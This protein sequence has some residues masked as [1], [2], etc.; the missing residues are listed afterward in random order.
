M[1]E[2]GKDIITLINADGSIKYRSPSYAYVLGYDITEMEDRLIFENVHPDDAATLKELFLQLMSTS[3]A[4]AKGQWRQKHSDGSYRWMEGIGSNLLDDPDVRA[5]ACNFRDI[6]ADIEVKQQ[7]EKSNRELNQLFNSIDEVLYS[8]DRNPYRLTQMS[9]ACMK[10]YG[11]PSSDF[12]AN[13]TLWFDLILPEDSHVIR[14]MNKLAEKG[15]PGSCQYRIRHKDGSIRWIE[16]HVTPTL[17]KNG[18]LARIDGVN[19]DITERKNAEEAL[20]NNEK[21]FRAL[22]ENN[23]E[24]IALIDPSRQFLYLS[25]SIKGILGYEP[26]ELIGT[27]AFELYHPDD[28]THMSEFVRSLIDGNTLYEPQLLRARHKDGNWRWIELIATNQLSDPAV[29]ALVANFRDVTEKKNAEEALLNN[30]KKFRTLI[31]NSKDG[32]VLTNSEARFIYLSPAIKEIL[33]YDPEELIGKYAYDVIHADFQRSDIQNMLKTDSGSKQSAELVLKVKHK[34]GSWRWIEASISLRLNDPSI[35]AVVTNFH[36]VTEKKNAEEALLNSEQRFRKLIEKNKD[37]IGLTDS[38]QQFVYLSPSVKDILGYEPEELIGTGAFEQYHPDDLPAMADLARSIRSEANSSASAQVR[39]RHKDGSW[40]WIELTATNQLDDPAINAIVT[41]F[42][43]VTD[44]K[45]AEE[46][47][48]NSE[49]R[50]RTLIEN[51][52]EGIALSNRDRQYIYVTPSV[53]NILGYDPEELIGVRAIDIY[54]PDDQESMRALVASIREK[55]I[56]FGSN[57]VRIRH[58]NGEWRWIEL[59]ATNQ[60]DD[61]AVNAIVTNFRDVTERKKAEDELEQ[62]N[63]S[64]EKKVQERTIQLEESNKALES[65]S[66]MA[67][68]DLQA[69]LR[70]MSGYTAI[71]KEEYQNNLGEDGIVLLDTI[72]QQAKQM[73]KLVSDLLSFSRVSHTVLKEEKISLDEIVHDI[74]SHLHLTYTSPNVAEIKV[75]KLGC[76]SG[77]TSLIRQVWSNLIS[78]A[79]K[80]SS[81]KEKPLIEIGRIKNDTETVFF[82]K[83]NGAGFDT[84]NASKLFQVFQRLHGSSDFEGTGLGLALVKNIV[85]RHGGRVWAE[86]ELDNG[87]TFYFSIPD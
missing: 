12:F 54:H 57:L 73:S 44:K 72:S 85:A 60:F 28:L 10:L 11:Y 17:D 7:L 62:L 47:L 40:K 78:N 26:E 79:L 55:R 83:D 9:E 81:K 80:Y 59:I 77:D 31:E 84:K 43:D 51:N 64:L 42:R 74:C 48:L 34:N 36:D 20:L 49:K 35:N 76:S 27:K 3:G 46:A 86:S 39:I 32:I 15:E 71:L 58:K 33:G 14:E 30:E 13:D 67:A 68:H 19:R 75:H 61:P 52:K 18:K 4:S 22:I 66:S 6:T 25:P 2:H 63:H 24:G 5:I 69:P 87:A 41:N 45:K 23:K 1:I 53:K 82:I 21:R 65:F 37:G 16:A 70:V 56:P 50:F 29:N 38:N 8:A